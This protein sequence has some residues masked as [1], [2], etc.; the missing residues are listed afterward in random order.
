M[1]VQVATCS[2]AQLFSGCLLPEQ[3]A[4]E[5]RIISSAGDAIVGELKI[6]EYQRPY[7]W[8][9]TQLRVLLQD[10]AEHSE[11]HQELPY[12]LGSL[13]LH[14]TSEK[15]N[16]IDGQQRITTLALM[17][18]VLGKLIKS[19]T[20][21]VSGLMYEHPISQQQIKH[22]LKWLQQYFDH[23]P[24]YWQRL[25]DFDKL[26]FTLVITLSEDDAYRF[27]ETQN[28]GGVR[29]K[30]TDIIKAHHLR[31]VDKV[32][33]KQFAKQWEAL[34][35]LDDAVNALLKGRYW[36]GI[37]MRA[38]PSHQQKKQVRDCI[39]SELAQQTSNG[40]KDVAYS[41]IHRHTGLTGE[42][43]HHLAQQ[44]YDVRQPLNAGVNTI[45]YLSYFQGLYKDYWDKPDL[46]HL[47]EYQRFIDWLK[48]LE[49]CGYLEGLYKACLLL[50]ISQF[51]ENQ[52]D[53]AAKK[54]FRVVYSR[55][56]SNQKAVRENSIPAF[57]KTYPVLDWVGLSY[58]PEQCF[59]YLDRFVLTVD[60][61]NLDKNSVKKRYMDKVKEYFALDLTP[62][63][64]NEH[65]A[66]ALTQKVAGGP[67]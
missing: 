16:I 67:R 66:S 9:D 4:T 49:G 65:F 5:E 48:R 26:H 61:S 10:L 43:T 64:Y 55:R 35:E 23:R 44:G 51:G 33:Q 19:E 21:L 38:L 60:S 31:A 28:T 3:P 57:V 50:Y 15:L 39:V 14:Q 8:R 24:E 32:Y 56:V 62:E 46:P 52:L 34:G 1:K 45:R 20:S 63:Q 18:C 2:A 36:Q 54:L 30:G 58:T 41:R 6:P 37:E 29:L 22:N 17:A 11:Q 59:A 27:F 7:C 53:L 13:I 42:V 12:Y 25:I 40:V 47:Q